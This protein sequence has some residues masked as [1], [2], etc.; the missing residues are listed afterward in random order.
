MGPARAR[1]F[2]IFKASGA[3]E[4]IAYVQFC[5]LRRIKD[6][7]SG[8][9]E[10]MSQKHA[11]KLTLMADNCATNKSNQM[12]AFCTELVQRGWF[13]EVQ[14][15]FGPVGHTHNGNDAVHF[16]HN[17][18]AG[19]YLSVTPAELFNNYKYAWPTEHT[20]PQPVILE[21]QW[22]WKSR[23]K[24]HMNPVSGFSATQSD[25]AYVR[26]FRFQKSPEN[27]EVE[28]HIKGS[29]REDTPWHGQNS[30]VNAPGYRILK[31]FPEN[32]P[33]RK[34]P[35]VTS[36]K[37]DY[38]HRLHNPAWLTH[39]S[40]NGTKKSHVLEFPGDGGLTNARNRE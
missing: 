8:S 1:T 9:H 4:A 15:L 29:P 17:Q 23:Y 35:Q 18:I 36:I 30:V 13:D 2:M 38:L 14:M 5:T 28:M 6:R 39:F 22:A 25:P 7:T 31:G 19:N 3:K 26:A 40:A 33:L 27:S 20:R 37:K 11:R 10:Q 32:A 34:R 12:F 16:I 24:P 21:S